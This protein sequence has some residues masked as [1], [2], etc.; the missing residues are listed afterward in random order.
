VIKATCIDGRKSNISS[1]HQHNNA[2]VTCEIKVEIILKLFKCFM[3]HV[4]T[5]DGKREIKH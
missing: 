4:T 2:V 1:D 3:S 5:V